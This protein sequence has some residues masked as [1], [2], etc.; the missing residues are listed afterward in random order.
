MMHKKAMR[1]RHVITTTQPPK[2]TH[3]IV[4]PPPYHTGKIKI[5]VYYKPPRQRQSDEDLMLQSLLLGDKTN[6]MPQ[7]HFDIKYLLYFVTGFIGYLVIMA[8]VR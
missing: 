6:F 7:F 4:Q 2:L 8:L 5:G 1:N 3:D